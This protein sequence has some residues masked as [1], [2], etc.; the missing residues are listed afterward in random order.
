MNFHLSPQG[1]LGTGASLLADISLLAYI[2]LIV[3]GMIAGYVFARRN[4][5]RPQHKWMM[6]IIT[7]VNWILIIFLMVASYGFDVAD[8]INQQPTNSRYLLPTIHGILG[9][10]AQLLATFI[11]VRM[12]LE[13]RNVALAKGRGETD[14]QKYWFKSAKPV[15]RLTLILWLITALFGILTYVTRYDLVSPFFLG[16]APTPAATEEIEPLATDEATPEPS[17]TEE[18]MATSEPIATEEMDDEPMATEEMDDE[19]EPDATEEMD[20]EP[21]PNATEEMDDDPEPS[22][23]EESS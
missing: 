15:M 3:P 1:F 10:P 21:E 13:D 12:F 6:T 18:M 17:A 19:P 11:I 2:L 9:L 20:D 8:G 14:L 22:S 23:T 16:D 7:I 5:H 4:M